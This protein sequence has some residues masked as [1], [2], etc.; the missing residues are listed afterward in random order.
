[1]DIKELQTNWNEFGKT[2]PL[3]AIL[4][5][6]GKENNKW[7]LDEFFGTGMQEIDDRMN[8]V[9]SLGLKISREKA[10]DFGCGV[11]RLTQA[12]AY[13]FNEV[14]GVDIAPSMIELARKYNR[15]G[16]R[17]RYI[18]NDADDL[19][20]FP[21]DSFDFIYSNITLQH[22]KPRYSKRYIKEFVRTLSS[23]GLMIFQLPSAPTT[24]NSDDGKRLGQLVKSTIPTPLLGL[25]RKMRYGGTRPIMKMHGVGRNDVTSV[26]EENGAE[27]LD[28]KQ[29]QMAEEGWVSLWYCV[30]N[31]IKAALKE[32]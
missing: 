5:Y 29:Y 30:R 13:H 9:H 28:I 4:T 19:S 11:G 1:M 26:L 12:L 21:D 20:L 10:L 17:C 3:Y 15:H 32:L 16:D 6:E 25:Y 23:D 27:I 18:L 14:F 2:D 24:S 31:R 7:D 22:M 8:H